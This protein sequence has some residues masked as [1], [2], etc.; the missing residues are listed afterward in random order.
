MKILKIVSIAI[1]VVL[2]VIAVVAPIGPMP[3]FFIGGTATPPPAT[4]P[5]TSDIDEITL[6]APGMLPRVVIIWVVEHLGELYVVGANDSGW[7]SM[8]GQSA[9]VEMRLE[10]NTYT[11][12]AKRV[13][14]DWASVLNAYVEKYRPGYPEIINS[15]PPIEEAAG[16][17]A[18]FQLQ[19]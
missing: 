3:G 4:W 2:I 7:V 17:I 14:E 6:K 16:A 12:Q 11:L 18:V 9:P 8:L 13:T 15:F 1:V 19:R 5:D 10:D